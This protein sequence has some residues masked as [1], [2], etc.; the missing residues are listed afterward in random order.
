MN[1]FVS[2]GKKCSCWTMRDVPVFCGQGGLLRQ[3]SELEF[4][5]HMG[6]A[7]KKFESAQTTM[8]P[9]S[10]GPPISAQS[11]GPYSR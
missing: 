8:Q 5:T 10:D 2:V 9:R 6:Y 7:H 3:K 1:K 11:S 4:D